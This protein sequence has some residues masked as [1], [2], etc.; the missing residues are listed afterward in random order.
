LGPFVIHGQIGEAFH[1]AQVIA[2]AIRKKE[3]MWEYLRE[4]SKQ[5]YPTLEQ[6]LS[7]SN[8][9]QYAPRRS[10]GLRHSILTQASEG[11]TLA[12]KTKRPRKLS[13]YWTVHRLGALF[14]NDIHEAVDRVPYPNLASVINEIKVIRAERAVAVAPAGPTRSSLSLPAAGEGQPIQ[15]LNPAEVADEEQARAHSVTSDAILITD[16]RRGTK[17]PLSDT[18]SAPGSAQEA[19]KRARI[20]NERERSGPVSSPAQAATRRAQA[21]NRRSSSTPMVSSSP[22]ARPES[23]AAVQQPPMAHNHEARPAFDPG[24]SQTAEQM[25][26][27]ITTPTLVPRPAQVTPQGLRADLASRVI[28]GPPTHPSEEQQVNREQQLLVA[29]QKLES[30]H[31]QAQDLRQSDSDDERTNRFLRAPGRE[32]VQQAT[33]PQTNTSQVPRPQNREMAQVSRENVPVA[34]LQARRNPGMANAGSSMAVCSRAQV[35]SQPPWQAR[36][37]ALRSSLIPPVRQ[38][39]QQSR[40]RTLAQAHIQPANHPHQQDPGQRQYPG[41]P[42]IQSEDARMQDAQQTRASGQWEREELLGR[43]QVFQSATPAPAVGPNYPPL[44]Q[45]VANAAAPPYYLA[46][47]QYPVPH[48]NAPQFPFPEQAIIDFRTVIQLD[49]NAPQRLHAE[50]RAHVDTLVQLMNAQYRLID[51]SLRH[52]PQWARQTPQERDWRVHHMLQEQFRGTEAALQARFPQLNVTDLQENPD[53]LQRQLFSLARVLS[54]ANPP[55]AGSSPGFL[56]WH[57]D[58]CHLEARDRQ[59]LIVRLWVRHWQQTLAELQ[60]LARVG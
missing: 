47:D 35:T 2:T 1:D 13:P 32:Y 28:N 36:S 37:S 31:L 53:L 21:G 14:G 40:G 4:Q 50:E 12:G 55:P 44:P 42:P 60:N 22:V 52:A 9:V 38:P 56:R 49:P 20:E 59:L 19:I 34:Q 17:R 43:S 58:C 5:A 8:T 26:A 33:Q 24:Q 45:V 41:E 48:N 29:K 57:W 51:E 30:A 25:A 6:L 46:E 54:I 7:S 18:A 39:L 15:D 23:R 11:Q 10:S 3:T 27:P 16:A